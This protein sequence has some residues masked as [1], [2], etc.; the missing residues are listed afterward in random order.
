M[1]DGYITSKQLSGNE[2]NTGVA[3]TEAKT[4]KERH[5]NALQ[6]AEQMASQLLKEE[7]EKKESNIKKEKRKKKT[8]AASKE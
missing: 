3:R 5:D 7:R 1:S 2:A 4:A 8:V 6:L